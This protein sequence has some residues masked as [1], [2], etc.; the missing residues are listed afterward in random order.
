MPE[1]VNAATVVRQKYF[2]VEIRDDGIVLLRRNSTPYA[3]LRAVNEAYDA[4]LKLVDDWL[5]DRRIKSGAL[6]TRGK[7]PVGW[8]YDIRF[9]PG[10]RNDPEFEGAVAARRRDLY[11]RSP[12]LAVLVRTAAGRMQLTRMSR[13]AKDPIEVF[14]DENE[15]IAWLKRKM[16][17]TFKQG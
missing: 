4:F 8:L 7:L 1:P 2:D 12:L 9:G 17:K 3:N 11:D 14:S 10:Q 6:G 5:L 16:Q 13:G 15:A